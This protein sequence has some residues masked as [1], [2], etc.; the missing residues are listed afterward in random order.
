EFPECTRM[1][2]NAE[3]RTV[4]TMPA[5]TPSA[6]LAFSA[7]QIDFTDDTPGKQIWIIRRDDFT[8]EFVSWSPRKTVVTALELQIRIAYAAHEQTNQ[9]ES[10]R[11]LGP[12]H[13]S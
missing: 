1:P 13:I 12:A 2:N 8:N 9:R 11:T 6:P 7:R 10:G 5:Q 3:H 4:R